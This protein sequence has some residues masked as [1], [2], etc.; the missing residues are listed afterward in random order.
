MPN[1]HRDAIMS[2]ESPF[3]P[4]PHGA[5]V[6]RAERHRVDVP[7][8]VVAFALEAHE[9]VRLYGLHAQPNASERVAAGERY[10]FVAPEASTKTLEAL[11]VA[12]AAELERRAQ[13]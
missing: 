11:A 4:R 7:A 9:V 10:V 1:P 8:C 5:T 12:V 3:T 13:P 6:V 2:T